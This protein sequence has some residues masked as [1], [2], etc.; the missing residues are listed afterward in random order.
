MWYNATDSRDFQ[1]FS[2]DRH[3]WPWNEAS[4][5][6]QAIYA[7]WIQHCEYTSLTSTQAHTKAVEDVREDMTKLKEDISNLKQEMANLVQALT[8]NMET[9]AGF[10]W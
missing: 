8:S 5:T 1:A 3:P 4:C 6:K 2:Y 7:I 10:N 9:T